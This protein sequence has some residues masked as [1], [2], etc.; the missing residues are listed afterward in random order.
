M[1]AF[2][3]EVIEQY[4]VRGGAPR[5]VIGNLSGG[6]LQKIVIGRELD[7]D[8]ALIIANQPTRGLDVGSIEFVHKS[9]LRAR[10]RGAGVLL[11][12]AELEEIMTLSDRIVVM[13]DGVIAGPFAR[14]ELTNF[15]IGALMAG[16]SVED[17][18]EPTILPAQS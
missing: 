13:Y 18:Q 17:A 10:E 6:N 11:V 15:E 5:R 2:A 1:Y 4:V 12:S 9:L 3:R 8:P 7:G 14:G 16:Q